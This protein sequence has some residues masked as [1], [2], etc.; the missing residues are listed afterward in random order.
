MSEINGS[1]SVSSAEN[2]SANNRLAD[3][4]AEDLEEDWRECMDMITDDSKPHFYSILLM[5]TNLG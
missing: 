1:K 4:E 5:L 3:K 2:E